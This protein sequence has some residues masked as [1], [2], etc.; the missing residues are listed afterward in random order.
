M[1]RP[2]PRRT[3]A[4]DASSSGFSAVR[5]QWPLAAFAQQPERMR[6]IGIL[7]PARADDA[8]NQTRVGAF[9]QATGAIGLDPRPQRARLTPAGPE[10][11]PPKFADMRRKWLRSRRTSSWPMAPR[12]WGRYC[13]RLAPCR[14]CSR[15]SPIRSVRLR[16]KPGAAGRQRHRFHDRRIQHRRK[17]AG[18]AQA[19]RAGRDASGGPSGP[20]PRLRNQ[21][22]CRHPGRGAVAQDRGKPDQDAQRRRDRACH[23]GFRAHSEWRPDHDGERDD[24][25]LSRSDHHASG[26]IQAA[27]GLFQPLFRRRRRPGLLRARYLDQYRRAAGYVDRILKGEKPADMP[28]QAPTKFER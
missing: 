4:D 2:A 15:L 11:I 3:H 27:G 18:T 12:P 24:A 6:L 5:R 10:P 7:L 19:D 16:R 23:R 21:P 14:S 26:A 9:L 1:L 13:R 8:D 25:D 20:H 17:I 28:V 22:V